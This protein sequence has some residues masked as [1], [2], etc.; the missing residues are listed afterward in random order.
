MV[1]ETFRKLANLVECKAHMHVFTDHE[2]LLFDF[3]PLA[4]EPCSSAKRFSELCDGH[5]F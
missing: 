5:C 1:V 3:S 2:S 4:F